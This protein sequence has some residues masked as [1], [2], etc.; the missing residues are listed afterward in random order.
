MT[1]DGT[2]SDQPAYLL[3]AVGTA[4]YLAV[5]LTAGQFAPVEYAAA[6]IPMVITI[7]VILLSR[8]FLGPDG[9]APVFR[10]AAIGAAVVVVVLAVLTV[11]HPS[12]REFVV[13]RDC[14]RGHRGRQPGRR[15]RARSHPS[16]RRGA[17]ALG[18]AG[19]AGVRS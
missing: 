10:G 12:V 1:C 5:Q 19:H 18:P 8:R 3:I 15:V 13:D 16:R 17:R 14:S 9:T 7:P 4:L 6:V 11:V 2:R